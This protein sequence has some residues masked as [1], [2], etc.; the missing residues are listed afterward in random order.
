MKRCSD[1]AS[2]LFIIHIL[3]LLMVHQHYTKYLE[4]DENWEKN[5]QQD[6]IALLNLGG[7]EQINLDE[8]INLKDDQNAWYLRSFMGL[9]FFRVWWTGGISEKAKKIRHGLYTDGIL[10]ARIIQ[11]YH[12]PKGWTKNQGM[13]RIMLNEFKTIRFITRKTWRASSTHC[14]DRLTKLRK[15]RLPLN[16]NH[17]R[18][19]VVVVWDMNRTASHLL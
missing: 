11:E 9:H 16:L 13:T 10:K 19:E 15:V 17:T 2:R 14:F 5:T 4:N 6:W 3:V 8:I 1:T 12:I 7:R 18:S